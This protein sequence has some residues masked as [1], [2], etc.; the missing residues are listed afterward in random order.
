MVLSYYLLWLPYRL[1]WRCLYWLNRNPE[2]AFYC[3]E[4]LD[5]VIFE[6]VRSYLPNVLIIAKNRAI[7]AELA[8]HGVE[9]RLYPQFPKTLI[10]ARHALHLFPE[11]PIRK[12]GLRH[13]AF[14]FKNFI[15]AESYNAFDLFL[16]TSSAEVKLAEQTGIKTM[17]AVGFPKLDPAFD[18]S[19]TA[20][21][22]AALRQKLGFTENKP[23][24][25]FSATWDGSGMSAVVRWA[26]RIG[27]LVGLYHI[28]V[29]VHNWTS[30]CFVNKLRQTAGITFLDDKNTLPYLMLADVMVSDT[31]SIIAEFCAL[32]KPL[33]TFRVGQ[34]KR[35]SDLIAQMLT[36]I[37]YQIDTFDDLK[38]VIDDVLQFPARQAPARHKWNQIMFD[39]LD[40]QAGRRAAAA[41][42]SAEKA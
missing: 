34:A 24:V 23:V 19:I 20:A 3:A 11:A 5:Y 14:C 42:L 15:R 13:G 18:G 12:I 16:A 37:S 32:D 7:Q 17:T 4:Y 28:L 26:D 41:I 25:L 40:G 8:A 21:D 38:T 33:I 2:L 35:Q 22:L 36:E 27:E 29:T 6:P 31:S 30:A 9:S 39:V 10:M 1:I